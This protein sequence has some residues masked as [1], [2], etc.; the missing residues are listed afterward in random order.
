MTCKWCDKIGTHSP[1][2]C[3]S[4]P[5]N[6]PDKSKTRTPSNPPSHPP[7]TKKDPP[8]TS[9]GK[10]FKNK[11]PNRF[12]KTP[13]NVRLVEAENSDAEVDV[14]TVDDE[15]NHPGTE[16]EN[17]DFPDSDTLNNVMYEEDD[18][19]MVRLNL[20]GRRRKRRRRH[21]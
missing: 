10:N 13:K 4:N 18:Q 21:Q 9:P 5:R 16:C 11:T 6:K 12:S 1:D 17:S 8:K 2:E 15:P 3:R 19:N 14:T 7:F 20:P